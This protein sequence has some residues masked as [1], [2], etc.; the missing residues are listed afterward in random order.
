MVHSTVF[1]GTERRRVWSPEDRQ[2]ILLEA[3]APGA[4]AAEVARRYDISTG[5]LYTWRKKVLSTTPAP[6]F[7]PAVV[8]GEAARCGETHSAIVVELAGGARVS[9]SYTAPER[10][11]TAILRGLR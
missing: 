5:L 1:A 10:L 3:F 11:V 8:T 9:I 4:V 6:A 2:R 7:L